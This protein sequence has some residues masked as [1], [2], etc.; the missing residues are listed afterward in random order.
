M[1]SRLP[2]R[3]NAG[4]IEGNPGEQE[5]SDALLELVAK[6]EAVLVR[7]LPAHHQELAMEFGD[8]V[9]EEKYRAAF[10]VLDRA[11]RL[12]DWHAPVSVVG[13]REKLMVVF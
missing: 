11:C 2:G 8:C 10:A 6:I 3:D 5:V 7:E 13:F 1:I 9:R 12:P 4:C